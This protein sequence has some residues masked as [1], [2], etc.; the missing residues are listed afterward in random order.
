MLDDDLIYIRIHASSNSIL[1]LLRLQFLIVE[2][3]YL[4]FNRNRE[5]SLIKHSTN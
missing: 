3:F 4:S 2:N 1:L 5:T